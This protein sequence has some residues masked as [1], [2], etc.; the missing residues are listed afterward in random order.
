MWEVPL[1]SLQE[2]VCKN[3]FLFRSINNIVN[4]KICK[5]YSLIIFCCFYCFLN[6]QKGTIWEKKN[7]ENKLDV[8]WNDTC[9]HHFRKESTEKIYYFIT[10]PKCNFLRRCL[11]IFLISKQ[12]IVINILHFIFWKILF[13]PRCSIVR[14]ICDFS[15]RTAFEKLILSYQIF[16][17][18]L[19]WFG[20]IA[21]VLL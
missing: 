15:T 6:V 14:G 13:L 21:S 16:P 10:F 3:I 19:I 8:F 18:P 9:V 4:V 12:N 5:K 20:A 11:C 17:F 7:V 1:S 2:I